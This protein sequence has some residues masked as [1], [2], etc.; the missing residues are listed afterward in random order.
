MIRLIIFDIDKTLALP[1]QPIAQHIVEQLQLIESKG[2]RVALISSKPATYISGFARQLG[3]QKPIILGEH[4][5]IIYYSAK[6]PPEKEISMIG[7]NEDVFS[8]IESIKSS[9]IS[10]YNDSVWLQPNTINLTIFPESPCKDSL[11]DIKTYIEETLQD[12]RGNFE[13]LILTCL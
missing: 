5:A 13:K 6:F 1:N 11:D 3:L 7:T 2:I 9:I 12:K 8:A 4:G 10:K